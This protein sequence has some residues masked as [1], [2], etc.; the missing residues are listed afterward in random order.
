MYLIYFSEHVFTIN[1]IFEIRNQVDT[2]VFKF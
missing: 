2:T 1:Y